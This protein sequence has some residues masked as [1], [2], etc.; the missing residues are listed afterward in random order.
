MA[1]DPPLRS[2]ILRARANV[3]RTR[4]SL[5]G[6]RRRLTPTTLGLNWGHLTWP[7]LGSWGGSGK[8]YDRGSPRLSKHPVLG[9]ANVWSRKLDNTDVCPRHQ[10]QT[11]M[12]LNLRLY[13]N[14]GPWFIR[15][16]RVA[17]SCKG[18]QEPGCRKLENRP[19]ALSKAIRIC[20]WGTP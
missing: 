10:A 1:V 15:D 8:H 9:T 11:T 5:K 7:Q 19:K 3:K 20:L 2:L 16:K 4:W 14:C 6:R 17:E 18:C 12:D 13:T